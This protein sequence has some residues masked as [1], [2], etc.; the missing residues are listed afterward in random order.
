M[1]CLLPWSTFYFP[2]PNLYQQTVKNLQLL[3]FTVGVDASSERESEK[4]LPMIVR[5]VTEESLKMDSLSPCLCLQVELL[6][7]CFMQLRPL[8]QANSIPYLN[9]VR[10]SVGNTNANMG[11]HTS[12]RTE[13]TEQQPNLYVLVPETGNTN[14][15]FRPGSFKFNLSGKF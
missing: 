9:L 2:P 15:C 13:L 7:T 4:L 3:P 8:S 1:C 11:Q 14:I 10:L 12:L 6:L 5:Y